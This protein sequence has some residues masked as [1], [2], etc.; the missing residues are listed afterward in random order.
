[1]SKIVASFFQ[2]FHAFIFFVQVGSFLCFL[3]DYIVPMYFYVPKEFLEAE[4]AEPGSQPRL[5][6]AEGDVDNLFMMGQALHIISK[7]LC[8][9]IFVLE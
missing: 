5:P 8:E 4:R 3:A 2:G 6:S 9:L 1:M 7:L